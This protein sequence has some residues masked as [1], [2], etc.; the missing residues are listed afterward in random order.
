M[1]LWFKLEKCNTGELSN[2]E[3]VSI[4]TIPEQ[5]CFYGA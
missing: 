3:F 4:F 1:G 5:A 2:V